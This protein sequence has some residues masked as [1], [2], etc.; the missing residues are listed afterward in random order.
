MNTVSVGYTRG[1]TVQPSMQFANTNLNHH[2]KPGLNI[3]ILN[4]WSGKLEVFKNFNTHIEGSPQ[5]EKMITFLNTL[6]TDRIVVG[7][8][9]GEAFQG[10][11]YNPRAQMA[12]VSC[13]FHSIH[14]QMLMIIMSI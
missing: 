5:I 4:S 2:L 11:R 9:K 13:N 6:P 7:V 8:V 3:A 14:E 1:T 12:L 10:I